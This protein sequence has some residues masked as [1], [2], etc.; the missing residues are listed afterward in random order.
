MDF[1]RWSCADQTGQCPLDPAIDTSNELEAPPR[2][3]C[4]VN[5]A[6]DEPWRGMN[7]HSQFKCVVIDNTLDE[8]EGQGQRD[9]TSLGNVALLSELHDGQGPNTDELQF[10]RCFVACPEN[11]IDC[12]LDCDGAVCAESSEPPFLLEANPRATKIACEPVS[13]A[14]GGVT[15]DDVGFVAVRYKAPY[16]LDGDGNVERGCIDESLLGPWKDLCPGRIENPSGVKAL[17]NTNNFGELGCGCDFNF[18]GVGCTTGCPTE[19]VHYGNVP[20]EEILC[21]NDAECPEG[22]ICLDGACIRDGICDNESGYCPLDVQSKTRKGFWMC[23]E[24]T[25]TAYT[26]PDGGNQALGGEANCGP[27]QDQPCFNMKAQ[28]GDHLNTR[29]LMDTP[30]CQ[31]E[32]PSTPCFSLH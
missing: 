29:N 22:L 10:N 32:D 23:G 18:G 17:D 30:G 12:S 9:E 13:A 14:D 16:S 7:H 6:D 28:S 8:R 25:R 31:D 11:D 19:L 26:V 27:D 5:L 20:L 3:L 1:G 4:Q 24:F 21:A 15:A 2:G